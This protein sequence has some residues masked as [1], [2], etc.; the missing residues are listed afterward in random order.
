MASLAALLPYLAALMVWQAT[1][2]A[3][4]V[5]T[6]HRILP[7]RMAILCALAFPAVFVNLGH[8]HNGFLTAGLMGS[9]LLCLPRRELLAGVLFALVAYKP[10]FGLVVPVALAAGGRWRAMVAATL[11]LAAMTA[12]T[13]AAFGAGSWSAFR[14]SWAFTRIV[15]LEQGNTGWEKIQSVFSAVRM[16]GGGIRTAYAIQAVVTLL[17]LGTLFHLWCRPGDFRVQGAALL[18]GSLLTTPYCLDYDM[19]LLG[20]A[21]GFMASYGLERGFLPWEKTLLAAIWLSPLLARMVAQHLMIPLG[22]AAIA[23]TF[24]LACWRGQTRP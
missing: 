19:M 4:Y 11:A 2:L 5:A 13:I 7:G 24:A 1:T 22:L 12:G 8:G 10:Q 17:V 18:S 20:P 14:Q 23:A 3:F 9:A 6:M 15:V 21:L 16:W